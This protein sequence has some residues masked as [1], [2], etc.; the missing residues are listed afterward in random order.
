MNHHLPPPPLSPPNP[1]DTGIVLR[2]PLARA[3]QAARGV[4][5]RHG[6]PAGVVV[7]RAGKRITQNRGPASVVGPCPARPTAHPRCAAAWV[8]RLAR[9]PRRCWVCVQDGSN[10]TATGAQPRRCECVSGIRRCECVSG[11]SSCS[12][13]FLTSSPDLSSWIQGT[14]CSQPVFTRSPILEDILCVANHSLIT[15]V[16]FP[17][18]Q[19]SCL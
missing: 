12:K 14:T 2:R 11:I 19:P 4:P 9:D 17:T 13:M 3:P 5:A 1:T 8:R 15:I 10:G 16:R 7:G 18:G 6:A